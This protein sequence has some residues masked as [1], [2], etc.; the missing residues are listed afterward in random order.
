M[1]DFHSCSTGLLS[2]YSRVLMVFEVIVFHTDVHMA[3]QSQGQPSVTML[4]CCMLCFP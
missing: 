2:C 4:L 3:I 1:L